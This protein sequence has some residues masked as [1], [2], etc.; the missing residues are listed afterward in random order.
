M[1]H[2]ILGVKRQDRVRNTTLLSKTGIIDVAKKAAMLKWDWAGHV[3]SMHCDRRAI[4]ST[5]WVPEE[6]RC[7]RRQPRKRWRDVLYAYRGC[8]YEM[9]QEKIYCKNLGRPSS[10]TVWAG[11]KKNLVS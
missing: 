4:V 9:A 6:E 5:Q 7:R 10:G 11:T 1:E 3:N 8:C 2:S